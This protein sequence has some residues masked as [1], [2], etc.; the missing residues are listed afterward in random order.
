MATDVLIPAVV[1]GSIVAAI[2]IIL[3]Y[4]TRR[5]II[6]RGQVDEGARD[7]F[8]RDAE[9]ARLSSLK[10]GMVLVGLGLA[11]LISYLNPRLFDDGGT[12]GLMLLFAGIGFLIYYAVAQR[13]LRNTGNDQS[14]IP[15]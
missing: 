10:W 5:I 1:F 8:R 4:R 11:L 9:L 12:F 2:K 15:A 13:I 14:N 6:E 7:F 3:D